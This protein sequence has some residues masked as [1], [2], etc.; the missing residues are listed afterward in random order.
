MVIPPKVLLLL[1]SVFAIL[2]FLL[3]LPF[4]MNLRIVLSMSLKNCV[5]ILMGI[6]LNQQIAFGRMDIFTMLILPIHEH[7]RSLH[8]LRSSSIS[9]LRDLKFLLYRCF[10]CVVRVTPGYFMSLVTAVKGEKQ[11]PCSECTLA[12]IQRVGL[13][14]SAL[15]GLRA[16]AVIQ[17]QDEEPDQ[18]TGRQK[19]WIP[20]TN[21]R[22]N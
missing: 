8:F 21:R 4:Q 20:I 3:L 14:R 1:R 17:K 12:V 19:K 7:G 5:G 2:D 13:C 11:Q 16:A 6:A 22:K 9:F 18:G 15:A 10:T